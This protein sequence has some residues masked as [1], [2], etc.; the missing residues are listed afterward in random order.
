MGAGVGRSVADAERMGCG[1]LIWSTVMPVAVDGRRLKSE[2]TLEMLALRLLLDVADE[3]DA[4]AE[5]GGLRRA[6]EGDDG[7]LRESDR[8]SGEIG[9]DD[10]A[11]DA[12]ARELTRNGRV[13]E[14]PRRDEMSLSVRERIIGRGVRSVPCGGMTSHVGDDGGE[15]AGRATEAAGA[16]HAGGGNE[17]D[18]CGEADRGGSIASNVR[19]GGCGDGSGVSTRYAS[20]VSPSRSAMPGL[21][22]CAN[23]DAGGDRSDAGSSSTRE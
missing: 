22:G 4:R 21:L 18:R 15:A 11:D 16:S 2:A 17:L 1:A 10:A 7:A 23:D 12:P 6:R 19:N 14:A 8:R 5:G 13:C 20:I 3:M 9:G